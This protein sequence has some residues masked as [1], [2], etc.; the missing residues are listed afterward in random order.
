MAQV[1]TESRR[2]P[3]FVVPKRHA[4]DVERKELL[5]HLQNRGDAKLITVVAP[6]GYGK[7]VALAQFARSTRTP[8]VWLSLTADDG[9]A[10]TLSRSVATAARYTVPELHLERYEQ[11]N[12]PTA[13]SERLAATLASDLNRVPANLIFIFEEL[14]HLTTDSGRWLTTF[15]RNLGEGHQVIASSRGEIEADFT[16]FSASGET[17]SVGIDNLAFDT[18][19][20]AQLLTRAGSTL[21]AGETH[22]ACD[23]WPA[24]IGMVAHGAPLKAPSYEL[25]SGIIK[26]FETDLQNALPE[27]AVSETWSEHMCRELGC[28]LPSSWLRRVRRSGLPILPLDHD[29]YRPH[30]VVL[31]VLERLLSQRP[32][33]HAALHLT[34]ARQ[35]ESAGELLPALDHL[36][37]GGHV[38]EALRLAEELLPQ[39]QMRS[40]WGLVR[41][42]LVPFK[43]SE[44]SSKLKTALATAFIET[45]EP[46]K[47]EVLLNEQ[48][49]DKTACGMTFFALGLLAY[50]QLKHQFV[51][52]LI[53]EGLEIANEQREII[54]LLRVKATALADLEQNKKALDT[55]NEAVRRAERLGD[56]SLQVGALLVLQYVIYKRGE[57]DQSIALCKRTIGLAFAANIPFKAYGAF[58]SLIHMYEL[59]GRADESL[60]LI[61]QMLEIGEAE[62]PLAVPRMLYRRAKYYLGSFGFEQA[63]TD[64]KKAFEGLEAFKDLELASAAAGEISECYATLG[65]FQEAELWLG[66]ANELTDFDTALAAANYYISEGKTYFCRGDLE[67]AQSALR[68]HEELEGDDLELIADDLVAD[69]Y[70]A[71]ISRQKGRLSFEQIEALVSAMDT[72]GNDSPLKTETYQLATLYQA[73]IERGW[74]SKRFTSLLEIKPHT[75]LELSRPAL[76][77]S[78]LGSFNTALNDQ[79]VVL[80]PKTRELV[81]YL[82][83]HGACPTEVLTDALWPHLPSDAARNNLKVQMRALKS[84]LEDAGFP[85]SALQLWSK[86]AGYDLRPLLC[87]TLDA[88]N[89]EHALKNADD[90]LRLAALEQYKGD[91]MEY[92]ETEWVTEA[93]SRYRELAI[94][95]ALSLGEANEATDPEYSLKFYQR[96]A[97]IEPLTEVA[98]EAIRRIGQRIG[99]ATEVRRAEQALEQVQ[100]GEIPTYPGQILN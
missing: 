92:S 79:T 9:E 71:E 80:S 44:L 88:Q 43:P 93:R 95:L 39:W 35:A 68:K 62:Y 46:A 52:D 91:F 40:D 16:R 70:L 87:I 7:T 3:K 82:A 26:T 60:E 24:A 25:V 32:A 58:D 28:S 86:N 98:Y 27:A 56:P 99:K 11:A 14:E 77:I 13:G 48:V 38:A 78:T 84:S 2:D 66:K 65:R 5:K 37:T 59:L 36:R 75:P 10:I 41:R 89:I 61:E 20:S 83:L 63:L 73:C 19:E 50:R 6:A 90:D 33:R 69:A 67:R 96:A 15:I 100:R 74:F 57:V 1:K 42:V 54:H 51:C 49:A 21:D 76:N 55:V 81:V 22:K 30:R 4:F 85:K 31:E 45:G 18:E 12:M 29:S 47:G 17:F 94:S 97:E 34:A 8:I 53:D 23:G 72:Y 64:Y